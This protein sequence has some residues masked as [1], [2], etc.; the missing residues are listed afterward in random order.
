M[1]GYEDPPL[2]LTDKAFPLAP[3]ELMVFYTDGYTEARE[4]ERKTQFGVERLGQ[5]VAGFGPEL[6]LEACADRARAAIDA[7]TRTPE[8]QDDLTLLLLRRGAAG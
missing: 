1:L 4:P 6:S 8:M 3:G 2:K 5:V 7:F